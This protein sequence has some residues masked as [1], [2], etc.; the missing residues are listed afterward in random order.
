ML[1]DWG[2]GR[3]SHKAVHRFL[4]MVQKFLHEGSFLCS[5]HVCCSCACTFSAMALLHEPPSPCMLPNP[6]AY[7]VVSMV[8]VRV[9]IIKG[10]LKTSCQNIVTPEEPIP[11]SCGPRMGAACPLA[12]RTSSREWRPGADTSLLEYRAH[13]TLYLGG[14]HF[15]E[16][17]V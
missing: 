16:C 11:G 9:C 14:I 17:M 13:V 3:N 5:L 12:E 6:E 8:L 1:R 7:L 15:I 10:A 2:L 4:H